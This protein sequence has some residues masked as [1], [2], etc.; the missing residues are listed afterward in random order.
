VL[1]LFSIPKPFTGDAGDRQR[2]ALASWR[3]LGDD[4]EVILVGDDEGVSGAAATT[5][6][7]HVGDVARNEAGTPRLDDAFRRL[8]AVAR[9]PLRCFV[10]ADIVLLDDFLPAL[11]CLLGWRSHWLALGRSRDAF[12]PIG[13]ADRADWQ[14]DVRRRA[15]AGVL[16]GA[17]AMDWFV[18]ER[19]L[20]ADLPPFAVG[21]A[22]FDNWMVWRARS[23]R[24]PV[25]DATADVV[26]VHQ[27][28]GYGHLA[29]GKREAYLGSEADRNREFAGGS[30]HLYSICD[31]THRLRDG[32][33]RRNPGAILRS[34]DLVRRARWKLGLDRTP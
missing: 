20:F 26:A 16:R 23:L 18:F 13:A 19:A 2:N 7:G 5:G 11:R 34:G 8:D 29:G 24:V 22:G 28:H 30:R 27:S 10:N 12:L 1:T 9:H 6:V 17:G 31:A 14:T 32:R 33:V 3:A 21:R 4:V 25:V 15:L